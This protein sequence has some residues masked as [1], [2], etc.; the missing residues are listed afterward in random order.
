MTIFR[1]KWLARIIPAVLCAAWALILIPHGP[2]EAANNC[3]LCNDP[4]DC[5]TSN[6]QCSNDTMVVLGRNICV[7]SCQRQYQNDNKHHC[8]FTNNNNDNCP[9]ETSKNCGKKLA[10][11]NKKRVDYVACTAADW[12]TWVNCNN[13]NTPISLTACD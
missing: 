2:V 13:T 6:C 3:K 7:R 9:N 11:T 4:W 5:N 8:K 10:N 12:G 1:S